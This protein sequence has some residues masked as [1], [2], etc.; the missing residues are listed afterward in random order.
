[1]VYTLLFLCSRFTP[2][3]LIKGELII[4]IVTPSAESEKAAQYELRDEELD[5]SSQR[6]FHSASMLLLASDSECRL[7]IDL[8]SNISGVIS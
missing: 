1:M 2:L 6:V 5:G 7:L 3:N 4:V 8:G